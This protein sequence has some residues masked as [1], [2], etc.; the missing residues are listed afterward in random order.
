[1]A[2]FEHYRSWSHLQSTP[3]AGVDLLEFKVEEVKVPVGQY[4]Y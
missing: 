1:M 3:I 2:N 4:Y